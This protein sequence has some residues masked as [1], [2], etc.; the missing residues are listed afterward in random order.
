MS[1]EQNTIRNNDINDAYNNPVSVSFFENI[2][3]LA[4]STFNYNVKE[5]TVENFTIINS[6]DYND[7]ITRNMIDLNNNHTNYNK[8]SEFI[9]NNS[10]QINEEII[11]FEK[12]SDLIKQTKYETIDN[13]GNL[14]F[15]NIDIEPTKMDALMQ[16]SIEN[17]LYHNSIFI[18]GTVFIA[19]FFIGFVAISL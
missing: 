1:I 19:S 16:D 8:Q 5:K 6:N 3:Y 15:N 9:N 11:Q 7:V 17:Q 13:E 10:N 4:S 2:Q 18:V 14:L 12:Y